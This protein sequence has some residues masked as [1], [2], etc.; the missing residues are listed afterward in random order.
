VARSPRSE[1][2]TLTRSGADLAALLAESR[3]YKGESLWND[4]W[5]RLK[6]NRTAWWSMVFLV[7]FGLVSVLAPLLPIPSPTAFV[8]TSQ[9]QPPGW[10]FAG[11]AEE[12]ESAL[13]GLPKGSR[14][15][16]RALGGIFDDGWRHRTVVTFEVDLGSG[17]ELEDRLERVVKQVSGRRPVIERGE[18]ADLP[19]REHLWIAVPMTPRDTGGT[20]FSSSGRQGE[21][22]VWTGRSSDERRVTWLECTLPVDEESIGAWSIQS[23]RRSH[24]LFLDFTRPADGGGTY[25]EVLT[26]AFSFP[27]D[28]PWRVVG[29]TVNGREL[30]TEQEGATGD[31]EPR[32]ASAT[33]IARSF[34]VSEAELAAPGDLRLELHGAEEGAALFERRALRAMEQRSLTKPNLGERIVA[35]IATSEDA[36]LGSEVTLVSSRSDDGYGWDVSWLDEQLLALRGRT[37]GLWQTGNWLGTDTGG[38]DLLA[39][40]VW[41]SRTSILVALA[42][43]L[44]SLLIG[45]TYG[46]LSGLLG[47]RIDNLMMR[48]VDILYSVPFIFV[49]IFLITIVGEY[50]GLLEDQYGIDRE[51]V[52]FIVIGAIYWLTMARVVRGQVL[53]LKNS[54]FIEA[55]RVVGASTRRILFV[56]LVPN[57]LSIVIVYL[58]LTIPAVML[59]EAFLSFLGLGIEPPKV[60]WGLLAANG[61]EAITKIR[62]FWWIVLFPALA[63]GSTLLALNILGDGLRDALDPKLRGSD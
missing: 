32:M 26:Y 41:G 36:A 39:R 30:P 24:R 44:C 60:S 6:A 23:V 46:A 56:H 2:W 16:S 31:S 28:A 52:F 19:G 62:V 43:T 27:D 1:R 35:H 22:E 38:R 42:A 5:R 29:C 10:R 53:S 15:Q 55:A 9:P 11:D 13:A 57:V 49:V 48:I 40:I 51:V 47:G 3:H 59:F 61:T 50:R 58:T 63:M 25:T 34:G 14:A 37:T 7:A 18:V 20:V 54:E 8:R 45:V 21:V 33:D 17:D 12:V 4:A